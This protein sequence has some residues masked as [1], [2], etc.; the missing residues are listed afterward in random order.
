MVNSIQSLK[1]AVTH[2]VRKVGV[3]LLI[4]AKFSDEPLFQV[5][6]VHVLVVDD[7]NHHVVGLKDVCSGKYEAGLKSLNAFASLSRK[8]G[9]AGELLVSLVRALAWHSGGVP[10]ACRPFTGNEVAL[11]PRPVSSAAPSVARRCASYDIMHVI[12]S[13]GYMRFSQVRAAHQCKRIYG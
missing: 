4:V 6:L 13:D 11:P 1:T 5:R 9:G 3:S 7:R 10:C 2:F 8:Q 12:Y